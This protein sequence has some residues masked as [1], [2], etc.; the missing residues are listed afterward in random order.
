[1]ESSNDLNKKM[2]NLSEKLAFLKKDKEEAY[3][4]SITT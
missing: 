1:M 3:E 4:I 2:L